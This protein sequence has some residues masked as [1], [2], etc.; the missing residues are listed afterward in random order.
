MGALRALGVLDRGLHDGT[1]PDPCPVPHGTGTSVVVDEET[2]W[3]GRASQEQ[4]ADLGQIRA[5]FPLG[6]APAEEAG[7]RS[8]LLAAEAA[9]FHVVGKQHAKGL[10][11]AARPRGM[12]LTPAA[13]AALPPTVGGP[14][15]GPLPLCLVPAPPPALQLNAVLRHLHLLMSTVRGGSGTPALGLLTS[16]C[17]TSHALSPS[18][19]TAGPAWPKAATPSPANLPV[20]LRS[21]PRASWPTAGPVSPKNIPLPYHQA[22][23]PPRSPLPEPPLPAGT[24]TVAPRTVPAGKDQAVLADL[25]PLIAEQSDAGE[26]SGF[27]GPSPTPVS[28]AWSPSKM[29]CSAL[30][31][32]PAASLVRGDGDGDGDAVIVGGHPPSLTPNHN[33]AVPFHVSSSLPSHSRPIPRLPPCL[34]EHQLLLQSEI[35][36]L[37]SPFNASTGSHEHH[38]SHRRPGMAQSGLPSSPAPFAALRHP[39]LSS[40]GVLGLTSSQ[41]LTPIRSAPHAPVPMDLSQLGT[42]AP[43]RPRAVPQAWAH[44]PVVPHDPDQDG[45]GYRGHP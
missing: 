42:P 8:A 5:G 37:G 19:G 35:I 17:D 27:S 3:R 9:D 6:L 21:R 41:H 18:A 4:A 29:A 23:S 31:P 20:P 40:G 24:L 43:G 28:Y 12:L 30:T 16:H 11:W 14:T 39:V 15:A 33:L 10:D 22:P 1:T 38:A 2:Y 34:F 25:P 7:A 32:L 26:H 45:L 13:P 36:D 44:S